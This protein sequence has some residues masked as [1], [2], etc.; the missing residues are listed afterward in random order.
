MNNNMKEMLGEVRKLL[1]EMGDDVDAIVF[2]AI[3]CSKKMGPEIVCGEGELLAHILGSA[4]ANTLED[5]PS[6]DDRIEFAA[7]LCRIIFNALEEEE[8]KKVN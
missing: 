4:V 6:E 1:D 3:S 7:N 2:S 8:E 5:I